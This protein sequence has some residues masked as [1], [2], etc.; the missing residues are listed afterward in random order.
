MWE[1]VR[2]S[3]K[4]QL[5]VNP[6]QLEH[7]FWVGPARFTRILKGM[8]EEGADAPE[9]QMGWGEGMVYVQEET[10]GVQQ[11]DHSIFVNVG[12]L[13]THFPTVEATRLRE[14][15]ADPNA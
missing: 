14:V 13:S 12:V 8:L 9:L 10:L 2:R 4:A 7:C 1:A 11:P 6:A 15:L 5:P 3:K